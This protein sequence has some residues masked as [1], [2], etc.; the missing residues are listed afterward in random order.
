[1]SRASKI[2]FSLSC[3]FTAATVVGVHFVQGLER[4]TLH[5]GPIKDARRT[6]A[7]KQ[8]KLQQQ[9]DESAAVDPDKERQ[10]LANLSEHELQQ[11]LRKKYEAIQPLSGQVVT[12][13]G[14]VV[15]NRSH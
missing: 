1:M 14:E 2:T 4:E 12:K 9:E 15:E 3:L 6:A 13:D 11:E 5:Q 10:K 7:R 8:Q